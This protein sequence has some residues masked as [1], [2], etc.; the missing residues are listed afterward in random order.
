MSRRIMSLPLLGALLLVF[1]P[2]T[3]ATTA[4]PPIVN[5]KVTIT[6][7][8]IVVAPKQAARGAYARFLLVNRGSQPHA[9]AFG[10]TR[11]GT[12]F[13]RFLRPREHKVLFFFL[14]S[15][16]TLGYRGTMRPDRS[17]QAMRGIFTVF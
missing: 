10:S 7:S 12:G 3:G 14:E 8:G 5:V 2:A 4:P 15:R 1:A 17:K 6:D 13:A 16:G 9:F 11:G